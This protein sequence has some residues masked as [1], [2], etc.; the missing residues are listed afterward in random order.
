M[1]LIDYRPRYASV[2]NIQPLLKT[3]GRSPP[4]LSALDL[5]P[6]RVVR[7]CLTLQDEV[8]SVFR[9]FFQ[10]VFYIRIIGIGGIL[11][12]VWKLKVPA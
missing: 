3:R 6:V 7:F 8:K 1:D 9:N 5:R 4:M 10:A 12:I 2:Q 11:Q